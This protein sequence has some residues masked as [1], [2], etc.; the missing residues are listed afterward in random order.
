MKKLGN[1]VYIIA[2]FV[3]VLLSMGAALAP[4]EQTTETEY[5]KLVV[6]YGGE[7]YEYTDRPVAP[8][9]FTVIEQIE[10][11]RINA[12]LPEKIAYMDECVA[13]GADYKTA[14]KQCFP[15]LV[16]ELDGIA[17]S[18]F[19]PPTDA[20][21]AYNNGVFSVTKEKSGRRLDEDKLYAGI[22]CAFKF[23]GGG[24]VKAYTAE[25]QPI[26]T[27][28]MLKAELLP[29][30]KYTTDF[31]NSSAERAH[32]VKLALSKIDGLIIPAGE[33]VS[34]NAIVGERT[35]ANGFKKAKIIVDGKYTDG[36]GG[37]VCQASTAVYNAA[38]IAGLH[39]QANAHSICPSYCPAGLDAMISSV[40]DLLITNVTTHSVY[41]SVSIDG[42]RGTVKV[43][44]E[45]PEYKVVPESVVVDTVSYET[46][47]QIDEEYKYFE[48][49][50]ESGSRLLVSPGKEGVS[51]ETYINLYSGDVLVKRVKVR[52]NTYRCV[53]QV[54]A[55]AP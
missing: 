22:Y 10:S 46:Q 20:K 53:P 48:R 17:R 33:T 37:G 49:G 27:S 52:E 23:S 25:I 15:V 42:R 43:F 2:F 9:D 14:V 12:P 41:I 30:G 35:E 24:Q 8:S 16:R 13:R 39:C 45:Q 36:Y 5:P 51:S 4:Q 32:N 11:R 6:Q 38:L 34:F 7:T 47:E 19:V 55:V 1:A 29:R 40:S 3:C 31:T 50:A 44:G 26:I 28:D 18:I 21:T 54:I